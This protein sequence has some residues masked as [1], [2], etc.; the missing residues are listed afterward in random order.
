MVSV[1]LLAGVG[2]FQVPPPLSSKVPSEML[3][4]AI[5]SLFAVGQSAGTGVRNW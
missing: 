1:F 4:V 5:S 2:E 3:H